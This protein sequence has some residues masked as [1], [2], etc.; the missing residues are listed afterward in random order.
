MC[1]HIDIVL[2]YYGNIVCVCLC[3][4][5]YVRACVQACSKNFMINFQCYVIHLQIIF[6]Q[7]YLAVTLL[8]KQS[9][10]NS[11]N[12]MY[13]VFGCEDNTPSGRAPK[14]LYTIEWKNHR[15]NAQTQVSSLLQNIFQHP[16]CIVLIVRVSSCSFLSCMNIIYFKII[17]DVTRKNMLTSHTLMKVKK[18][19]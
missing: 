13:A 6:L 16:S 19:H 7:F 12:T 11:Q 9:S 17:Q 10:W 15:W 18:E 14:Y 8:Y 1:R 3:A 4:Y 5:T 2:Y